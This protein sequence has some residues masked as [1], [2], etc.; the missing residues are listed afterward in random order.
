PRAECEPWTQRPWEPAFICREPRAASRE[1]RAASGVANLAWRGPQS[2][3]RNLTSDVTPVTAR[4]RAKQDNRTHAR[5]RQI[6]DT[7][8][9]TVSE[10][11]SAIEGLRA[12]SVP[13]L[14]DAR[15]E[16][17]LAELHRA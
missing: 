7:Q 1:P 6:R 2:T 8:A 17:D 11:R 12:E 5:D 3:S 4:A 10:L 13:E 15:I 14:P 16:E 9:A